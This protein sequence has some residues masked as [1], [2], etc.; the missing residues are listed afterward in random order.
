MPIPSA[1]TES[2]RP[3]RLSGDPIYWKDR[4]FSLLFEQRIDSIQ[5]WIAPI[6]MSAALIFI[7]F[8]APASKI[9]NYLL[10]YAVISPV[11][12]SIQIAALMY[13]EFQ[14][15][16]W[17]GLALLPTPRERLI[18]SKLRVAAATSI[19]AIPT[20]LTA[21]GVVTYRY[22]DLL[23]ITIVGTLAAV[24]F[25]PTF[26][27]FLASLP[28]TY[29]GNMTSLG[30]L[31]LATAGA[32]LSLFVWAFARSSSAGDLPGV[33]VTLLVAIA[34]TYVAYRAAVKA[35]EERGDE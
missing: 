21:L 33:V 23:V 7:Q 24:I 3:P 25:A 4:N 9:S 19:P 16:T 17:V 13:G 20:W 31:A 18:R 14:A 28:E 30:G 34:G 35:L 8:Y 5:T 11:L 15:K 29:E 32:V 27:A 12:P 10:F 6:V 22:P 26:V 2:S 1:W